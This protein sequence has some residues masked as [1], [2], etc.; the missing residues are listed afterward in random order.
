MAV[1]DR[2]VVPHLPSAFTGRLA[3]GMTLLA[4][5]LVVACAGGAGPAETHSDPFAYCAAVGTV[6]APDERYTGP[7]LPPSVAVGL[8]RA[9]GAPADAPLEAFTRGTSWRCMDG[10]VYACT[11]GANLPCLAKADTRRTPS[12]SITDFCRQNPTADVVPA[13]VSGRE[14]VYQ[15]RCAQGVP[16]VVRQVATPDAQGFLSNIW[17]EITS[18]R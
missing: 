10:K 6:D 9:V 4:A 16:A 13:F 5:S 11:V 1:P 8:R 17:H 15:W 7:P 3:A 2:G 12:H 18:G 14:T